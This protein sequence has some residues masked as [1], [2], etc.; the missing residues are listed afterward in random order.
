[1]ESF[2]SWRA[3]LLSATECREAAMKWEHLAQLADN[4]GDGVHASRARAE[5]SGWRQL[6]REKETEATFAPLP[7]EAQ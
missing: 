2:T 3:R 1:M 6:A 5:A 4:D 7:G